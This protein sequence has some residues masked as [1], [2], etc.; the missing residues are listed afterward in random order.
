[1][2]ERH[3]DSTGPAHQPTFEFSLR[4]RGLEVSADARLL[5]FMGGW[6]TQS[7]ST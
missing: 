2:E 6:I 4:L 3:E 7:K 5:Q 1:M